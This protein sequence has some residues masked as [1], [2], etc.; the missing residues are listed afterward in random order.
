M[1]GLEV[2]MERLRQL[3]L[4]LVGR[5]EVYC[6]SG[7]SGVVDDKVGGGDGRNAKESSPRSERR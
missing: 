7:S 1:K 3:V 2:E 5:E 6:A 4:A